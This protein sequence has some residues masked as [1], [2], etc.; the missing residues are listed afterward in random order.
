MCDY[1]AYWTGD[2]QASGWTNY[3]GQYDSGCSIWMAYENSASPITPYDWFVSGSSF[4]GYWKSNTT[5]NQ[6]TNPVQECINT[7]MC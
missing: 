4:F 5:N 1:N 6:W 2:N 3:F 7:Q